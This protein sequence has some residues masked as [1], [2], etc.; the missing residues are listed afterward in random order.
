MVIVV[1]GE[2]ADRVIQVSQL[3]ITF[4]IA[5]TVAVVWV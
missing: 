5:E 3:L 2:F 4:A 1:L